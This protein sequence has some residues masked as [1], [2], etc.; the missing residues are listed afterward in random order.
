MAE[1]AARILV[2]GSEVT[3]DFTLSPEQRRRIR[4]RVV[5]QTNGSWPTAV[6]ATLRSVAPTGI[7]RGN[8]A[9]DNALIRYERRDGTFEISDLLPGAYTISINSRSSTVDAE[10]IGGSIT[11]VVGDA[12]VEGEVIVLAGTRTAAKPAQ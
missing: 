6:T 7:E 9:A 12:D 5:E 1:R 4:G 3:A 10:P 11:V 8:F 2:G